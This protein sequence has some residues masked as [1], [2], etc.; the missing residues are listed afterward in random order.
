MLFLDFASFFKP[1][2]RKGSA[3]FGQERAAERNF[4]IY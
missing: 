1:N 3:E 2:K 4:K